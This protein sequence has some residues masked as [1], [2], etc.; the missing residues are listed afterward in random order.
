[1]P[2]TSGLGGMGHWGDDM[3][4]KAK[5]TCARSSMAT[6]YL[7]QTLSPHVL[8]PPLTHIAHVVYLIL[9]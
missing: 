4:V 6:A 5:T 1:M 7:V 8:G 9:S 2:E 3:V